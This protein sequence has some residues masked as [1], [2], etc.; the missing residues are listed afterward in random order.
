[1]LTPSQYGCESAT[2]RSRFQPLFRKG[3]NH[4]LPPYPLYHIYRLTVTLLL[5]K[6]GLGGIDYQSR[7]FKEMMRA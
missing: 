6:T 1:M 5:A 4:L 3:I 2:S 7:D